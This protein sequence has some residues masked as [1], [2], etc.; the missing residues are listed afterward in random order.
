MILAGSPDKVRVF[1]L[2]G[3]EVIGLRRPGGAVVAWSPDGGLI[4]TG[5]VDGSARISRLDLTGETIVLRGHRG[6]VYG[7]AFHPDGRRLATASLDRTVRLSLIDWGELVHA[8]RAAT[9]ACLT[10]DQRVT[11]LDES[12]DK[13]RAAWQ[14]CE[15]RFGRAP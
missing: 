11:H 6:P 5:L 1:S 14:A 9:T 8:L 4:A 2:D 15:R 3:S 10:V 12:H 7:V 13:A